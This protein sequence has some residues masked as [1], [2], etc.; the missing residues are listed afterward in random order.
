MEEDPRNPSPR[1][2]AAANVVYDAGI[3][4]RWTGPC[5]A[6]SYEDLERT[7]PIGFEE[8]N[9]IIADSLDAA[10]AVQRR[11]TSRFRLIFALGFISV[12]LLGTAGALMYQLLRSQGYL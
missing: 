4:H 10:D 6:T 2:R 7:D 5:Y 11:R 3:L 12:A 1:L 8:F 9:E